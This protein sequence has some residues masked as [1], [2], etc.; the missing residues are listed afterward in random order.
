MAA[1][2]YTSIVHKETK[3]LSLTS[4]TPQEFDILVEQTEKVFQEK[5]KTQTVKGK[6]RNS[7]KYTDYKNS[8]FKTKEDRLLLVLI[9]LKNNIT[10]ELLS[11]MFETTQ[12]KINTW[13]KMMLITLKESLRQAEYASARDN[14]RLQN[15]MN[16]TDAPLF[17]MME[18]S[19]ADKDLW[20]M[21]SR[22]SAIV[23]RKK[24]IP[25]KMVS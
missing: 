15:L 5:M 2:T 1:L 19:V 11:E 21:P 13:L 24:C 17:V 14:K 6:I 4:L 3:F 22:G 9:Y 25:I 7:R 16:K 23:G 8:P 20:R 18:P 12:P 10:Q